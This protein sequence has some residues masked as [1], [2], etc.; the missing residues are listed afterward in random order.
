VRIVR[1]GDSLWSIATDL[2]GPRASDADI[3]RLVERLWKLNHKQIATGDP[4]LL[5]VGT[6]LVLP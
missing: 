6:R 5:L 1:P 2:A 4:D 3:A